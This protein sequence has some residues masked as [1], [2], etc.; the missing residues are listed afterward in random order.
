MVSDD[1]AAPLAGRRIV[2]TRA[3]KAGRALSAR[4]GAL[5]ADAIGCPTIAVVPPLTWVPLDAALAR[6]AVFDWVVFTSASAVRAFSVRLGL[7]DLTRGLPATLRIAAVGTATA[8][9]ACSL[10]HAPDL[11]PQD[12]RAAGLVEA[13][14][15][16]MGERCLLPSSDIARPELARGLRSAGATVEV[17]TAYRTVP[18]TSAALGEVAHLLHAGTLDA[19]TLTS[20]STVAGFLDGLAGVGVMPGQLARLARRPVFCCIGPT[21]ATA[22]RDYGLPV[23]AI[24]DEQSDDGLVTAL[25][26]CLAGRPLADREGE[27][28][29]C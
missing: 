25:V 2:V 24:A 4:L 21:T 10:L 20:P 8:N 6:L 13:L 7:L 12:A 9:A 22:L 27:R 3:E 26:R 15:P 1:G 29:T 17:V 5:G 16:L 11:V 14:G 23:D 18:V 19:I 28:I